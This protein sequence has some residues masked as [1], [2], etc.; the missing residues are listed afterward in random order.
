MRLYQDLFFTVIYKI[1][2]DNF[3][4]VKIVIL[5]VIDIVWNHWFFL[6]Y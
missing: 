1:L 4:Y 5:Q 6:V 2:R 3:L